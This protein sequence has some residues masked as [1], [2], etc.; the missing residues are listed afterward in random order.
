MYKQVWLSSNMVCL[1]MGKTVALQGAWDH[2][3][4]TNFSTGTAS[5]VLLAFQGHSV[6]NCMEQV[7]A[8]HADSHL[9]TH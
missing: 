9:A 1:W 7:P 3:V 8:L 5:K 6:P 4:P 2:L